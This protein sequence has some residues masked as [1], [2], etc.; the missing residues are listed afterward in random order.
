[1]PSTSDLQIEFQTKI[2]CVFTEGGFTEFAP[3]IVLSGPAMELARKHLR[4]ILRVIRDRPVRYVPSQATQ[5][6]LNEERSNDPVTL[7]RRDLLVSF[8]D[9]PSN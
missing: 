3:L 4:K 7:P 2:H 8:A 1:M 5:P 9:P 6:E